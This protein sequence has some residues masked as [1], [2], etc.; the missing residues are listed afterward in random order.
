[1][2]T[3][4]FHI[5]P[6]TTSV[7]ALSGHSL[8]VPLRLDG[9][10]RRFLLSGCDWRFKVF[11][12]P[13][14]VDM[15][16]LEKDRDVSD[17]DVITVPSVWQALGYDRPQYTNVDYPIPIDPPYVPYDNPVGIYVKEFDIA[18]DSDRKILSFEGVDSAFHVF[19]NGEYAGSGK[20]S[21]SVNEFDVTP[22][23]ADGRNRLCVMVFKW[24]DGTYLEDQDKFRYTG[25]FRDV[26]LY[27]R[28][29]GGIEDF[30][31]SESFDE[32]YS[33]AEVSVHVDGGSDVEASV[34]DPD[35]NL[36]SKKTVEDSEAV[37]DIPEPRLW[38]AET[39]VLYTL[40][41]KCGDEEIHKRFGLREI[42]RDGR[43]VRLN[44]RK[45][46]FL[47]VNRHDSDPVTG[48]CVDRESILRD[49]TMMK[50]AN[51]NTIRTSHYP[52]P[53]FLYELASEMGFYVISEA[54]VECHG[55][56]HLYGGEHQS[57]FDTFAEGDMFFSQIVDRNLRNVREHVNETCVMVWSLGNESGYGKAFMESALEVRKL[58][59]SRLVHYEGAMHAK[60][61]RDGVDDSMLDMDSLMYN[62]V[63]YLKS[64][65]DDEE[66][67]KPLFMC[68]YIHSMGNGPGD[69]E[70]YIEAFRSDER[71]LGGCSWEWCDHAVDAGEG[72]NG[73]RLWHYGGDSGEFP[74][75]GN[76]CMDGLVFPDRTPHVGYY[77]YKNCLRPVRSRLVSFCDD[78]VELEFAN[79]YDFSDTLGIAVTYEVKNEK[80][81]LD[82]GR[83]HLPVIP[84]G[85]KAMYVLRL[86]S[87]LSGEC[88]IKLEYE[89]NGSVIGFDQHRLFEER[90]KD[91]YLVDC[92]KVDIR[93]T[94]DEFIIASPSFEYRF[95]KGRGVFTSMVCHGKERLARPMSY[96]IYRAPTDNDRKINVQWKAA[97]FD[98]PQVHVYSTSY[99]TT[100]EGVRISAVFSLVPVSLQRIAEVKATYEMDASGKVIFNFD[101]MRNTV[102]PDFPRFGIVL[103][104]S[105]EDD[106]YEYY[107]Y[108]PYESYED[109]HRA[110][111]IDTFSGKAA[112]LEERYVRP[113][114]NGS[115]FHVEHLRLGSLVAEGSLPFSFNVSYSSI[116]QL[117][118]ARHDYELERNDYPTLILDYRMCGV[119]SASCG[120]ELM[121]KYRITEEF[122]TWRIAVSFVDGVR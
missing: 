118:K 53:A 75:D 71:L 58:D 32:S 23:V 57:N 19:V 15:S 81:R 50:S 31:I 121:K 27:S 109:K 83:F 117:E 92:G 6:G 80:E 60:V 112:D 46:K 110:S 22:L 115:R 65:F 77:E 91:L 114:E 45:V 99:D 26:Y 64:Y 101:V 100:A 2:R 29:K 120:P 3:D 7:N 44:G 86:S 95:S 89:K 5:N 4:D 90:R 116:E 103:P 72:P 66:N 10:E 1:M 97:G 106:G 98:R 51:M 108:G 20:V 18:K 102:Y 16:Y 88:H 49:L 59:P 36:V 107:G 41:L 52:A 62:D 24:S 55:V 69:I 104:L 33:H 30:R 67:V 96:T 74:D 113:Q 119:G 34:L 78:S 82:Y 35:G 85:E 37:F 40:V 38:N 56:V 14:A 25:I 122:F 17:M 42:S 111:Y 73:L 70:E 43:V 84:S 79:F 8:F 76:F 48:P 87:R 61:R 94:V 68:E 105:D 93:E 11:A 21:H 9:S 54:D 12:R 13:E 47:G 63:G 28:Q 39:P